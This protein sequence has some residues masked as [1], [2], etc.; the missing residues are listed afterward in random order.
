VT[1]I[2]EFLRQDFERHESKVER[3]F[4]THVTRTVQTDWKQIE[5]LA[6]YQDTMEL[7]QNAAKVA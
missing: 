5:D 6:G 3:G 4:I 2:Q 1:R 7:C